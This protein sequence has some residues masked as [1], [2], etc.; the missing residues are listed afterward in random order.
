MT[1]RTSA[2]F[3]KMMNDDRWEGFGY[4]GE[5]RNAMANGKPVAA[6][7]A[8]VLED[9]SAQGLTYE[10]LFAWANSKAGR[11]Y[12]DCMFGANGTHA[13]KYLPGRNPAAR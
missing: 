5:R 12:G 13:Q 10:D 2:D 11:W 6:A 7:D 3:D 8:K 9:A 4:L 1:N